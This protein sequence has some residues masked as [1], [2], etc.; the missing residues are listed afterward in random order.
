MTERENVQS[1]DRESVVGSR[2]NALIKKKNVLSLKWW[3]NL[4]GDRVSKLITIEVN[5]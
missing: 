5:I 1:I 2:N 3:Q 4:P